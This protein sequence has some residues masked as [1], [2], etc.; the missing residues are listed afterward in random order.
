MIVKYSY[1]NK[2]NN[3]KKKKVRIV[4]FMIIFVKNQ[5]SCKNILVTFL[6]D[7]TA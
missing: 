5:M 1:E 4:L 6:T 3:Y 2:M 7:P